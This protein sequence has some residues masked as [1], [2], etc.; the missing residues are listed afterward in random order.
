MVGRDLWT[1]GCVMGRS[2]CWAGGIVSKV[3][4]GDR[5]GV[6]DMLCAVGVGW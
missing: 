3:F 5:V 2:V 6:V 1:V 4:V